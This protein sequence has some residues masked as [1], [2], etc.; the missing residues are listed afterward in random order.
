MAQELK[1]AETKAVPLSETVLD[2]LLQRIY[3]G[4]QAMGATSVLKGAVSGRIAGRD[5]A[6]PAKV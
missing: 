6:A 3:G 4:R 2:E 5:A 1:A